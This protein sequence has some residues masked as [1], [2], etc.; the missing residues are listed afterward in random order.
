MLLKDALRCSLFFLLLTS[1]YAFSQEDEEESASDDG[2]EEVVVTGSRIKRSNFETNAPVTVITSEDIENRGYTKAAEALLALPFVGIGAS[3]FGDSA[4]D[5]SE[6]IGQNI[7]DSFGLGAQRSLTLVNG[8]RFVSGNSAIGSLG[9]AVDTNNIPNALIDRVE[10]KSVGGAAVYGADAVAGVI[11]FILKEDYE[12][13]EFSYD[14][15]SLLAD[16]EL[17]LIHI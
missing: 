12:G 5:G 1:S 2:T 6:D 15:N 4:Y 13:F 7:G 3:N 17:S 11:N 16:F 10:V 9:S 14:Y 8:K